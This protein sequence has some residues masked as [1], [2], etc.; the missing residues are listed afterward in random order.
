MYDFYGDWTI[1]PKYGQYK[2]ISYGAQNLPGLLLFSPIKCSSTF[3]N[4]NMAKFRLRSIVKCWYLDFSRMRKFNSCAA[5]F[6]TALW[7][8]SVVR[9]S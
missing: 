5:N 2:S 4:L 6:P 9:C 3:E 1:G 8:A 7:A